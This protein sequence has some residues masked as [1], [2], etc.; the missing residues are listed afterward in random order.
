MRK[1]GFGRLSGRR[2]ALIERPIPISSPSRRRPHFRII[3]PRRNH[4]SHTLSRHR[5]AR[6]TYM[7]I[8]LAKDFDSQ[9]AVEELLFKQF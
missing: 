9:F 8:V 2:P 1:R 4:E 6:L 7:L 3:I 5:G